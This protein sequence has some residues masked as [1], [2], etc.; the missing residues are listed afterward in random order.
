MLYFLGKIGTIVWGYFS[1]KHNEQG[2]SLFLALVVSGVRPSPARNS[3]ATRWCGWLLGRWR[4]S[5]SM[6]QSTFP[7]TAIDVPNWEL[8][9]RQYCAHQIV[10]N[11]G[12]FP[13]PCIMGWIEAPTGSFNP[14][15]K[16]LRFRHCCCDYCVDRD[17]ARCPA[18]QDRIEVEKATEACP[19][20]MTR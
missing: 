17:K 3:S 9:R 4:Q 15:S 5:A 1:D 11:L 8:S 7:A 18:C 19:P 12:R 13:G 16:L 2:I 6:G 14:D 10:G 20:M